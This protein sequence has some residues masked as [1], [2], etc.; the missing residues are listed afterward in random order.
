MGKYV[1]PSLVTKQSSGQRLIEM[2]EKRKGHEQH[3]FIPREVV[4][5]HHR[6]RTGFLH[7][8]HRIPVGVGWQR[9][10]IIVILTDA[11]VEAGNCFPWDGK[12]VWEAFGVHDGSRV[13]K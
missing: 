2:E 1:S 12:V 7:A 9:L 4:E 11:A 5:R 6:R 10:P 3:C 8:G 13:T